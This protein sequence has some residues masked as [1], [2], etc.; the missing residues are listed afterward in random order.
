MYFAV[1]MSTLDTRLAKEGRPSAPGAGWMTSAP[2]A[3]ISTTYTLA[4][5]WIHTHYDC[6]VIG[7]VDAE[8]VEDGVDAAK[9]GIDSDTSL[10]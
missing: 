4:E 1:L 5:L 8:V 9:F 6:G 7:I 2:T 3:K 10:S